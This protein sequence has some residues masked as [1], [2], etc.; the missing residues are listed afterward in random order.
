MVGR[1]V[2]LRDRDRV[3]VLLELVGRAVRAE[4]GSGAV[5]AV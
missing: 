2:E 3:L 1:L 4:F 5:E